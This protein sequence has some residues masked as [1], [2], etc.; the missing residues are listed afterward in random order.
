MVIMIL[1]Q[2][3]MKFRL[4]NLSLAVFILASCKKDVT[5]ALNEDA[6]SFNVTPAATTYKIGQDVVFNFTGKADV[7]SFFSGELYHDYAFKGGRTL[8]MTNPT[9]A[10]TSAVTGGAQTNQLTV[11]AS[12]DFNGVYNDTLKVP[13]TDI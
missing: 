5:L 10:F 13:L 8:D 2:K 7:L 3:K 1:K 11:L 9:I 12:T 4:Y 6:P